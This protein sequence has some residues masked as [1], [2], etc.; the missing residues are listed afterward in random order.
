MLDS[1]GGVWKT[2][3]WWRTNSLPSVPRSPPA[4]LVAACPGRGGPST[5]QGLALSQNLVFSSYF[6]PFSPAPCRVWGGVG[7]RPGGR[8]AEELLEQHSWPERGKEH[9]RAW[10]GVTGLIT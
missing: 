10:V 2:I 6:P 1:R 5:P 4:P 3:F 7:A 8:E 9:P